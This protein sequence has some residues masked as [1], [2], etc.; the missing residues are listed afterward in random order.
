MK[1]LTS[2]WFEDVLF[3][4]LYDFAMYMEFTWVGIP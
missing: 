1:D 3:L 2:I 4:Y